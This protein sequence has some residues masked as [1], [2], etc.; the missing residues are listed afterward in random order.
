MNVETLI[1]QWVETAL[2]DPESAK[3]PLKNDPLPDWAQIK[4]SQL[5]ATPGEADFVMPIDV[6]NAAWRAAHAHASLKTKDGRPSG[7]VF[8]ALASLAS[9]LKK[10]PAG[11]WCLAFC[12][13]GPGAKDARRVYLPGYKE[14]PPQEMENPVPDVEAAFANVVGMTVKQAE[15]EGDDALVWIAQQSKIP[16]LVFSGDRDLWH[17]LS[18]R[19]RI[20]S[21]NLNRYVTVEDIFEEYHVRD[22][23]RIAITK[24]ICGERGDTIPSAVKGLEQAKMEP[25]LN[26]P[27]AVDVEGYYAALARLAPELCLTKD[28]RGKTARRWLSQKTLEKYEAGRQQAVT[29][30]KV[31]KAWTHGFG[32]QS[33]PRVTTAVELVAFKAMLDSWD[34]KS[35]DADIPLFCGAEFATAGAG[36]GTGGVAEINRQA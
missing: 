17:L 28:T 26:A 5:V 36:Y 30:Y 16:V 8:G 9:M 35:I 14:R 23:K 13:D 4:T 33:I 24:S 10:L 2:K 3:E 21:P 20:L 19:V 27:E 29:N 11:K 1:P 25:I 32:R 31:I 7:H 12:C 15:R 34:I 18:D 22:P 6:S